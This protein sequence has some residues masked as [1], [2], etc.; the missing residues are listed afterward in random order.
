MAEYANN[1]LKT[2]IV[3]IAGCIGF[4]DTLIKN[5]PTKLDPA[6]EH[7]KEMR[8][9]ADKVLVE[10]ERGLDQTQ[11]N[12]LMKF[13]KM[14]YISVR[15]KHAPNADE[16]YYMVSKT[17]LNRLLSDVIGDCSFCDKTPQAAKRC[18]RRKDLLECGIVTDR[19]SGECP[20]QG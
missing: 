3:A 12:S 8:D 11:V 13:A 18:Q 20:Y 7:I 2:C 17:A 15:P 6:V 9:A 16:D 14:H 5:H 19:S 4:A 10:A 1:V